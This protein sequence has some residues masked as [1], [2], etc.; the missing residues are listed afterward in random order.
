MIPII[1]CGN[2][3]IFKGIYLCSISIARRTESSLE[4]HIFTMNYLKQMKTI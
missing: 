2:K 1:F 3:K 4:I